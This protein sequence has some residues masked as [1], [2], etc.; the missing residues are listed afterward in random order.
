MDF[1]GVKSF[2]AKGKRLTSYQV[3]SIS[4]IEPVI[5]EDPDSQGEPEEMATELSHEEVIEDRSD[6]EVRDELTGQQ[7]IF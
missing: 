6:D 7:R 5:V 1:V 4:E 2:R 3:A